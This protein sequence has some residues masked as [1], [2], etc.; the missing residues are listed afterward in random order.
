MNDTDGQV[1]LLC[2]LRARERALADGWLQKRG[3]R[4]GQVGH[5]HARLAKSRNIVSVTVEHLAL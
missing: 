1:S 3:L 5:A 2:S 4:E